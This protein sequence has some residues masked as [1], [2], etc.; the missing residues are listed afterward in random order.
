MHGLSKLT[1]LTSLLLEKEKRD[2]E[3]KERL[4]GKRDGRMDEETKTSVKRLMGQIHSKES[5]DKRPQ[6]AHV[7]QALTMKFSTYLPACALYDRKNTAQ[8][9]IHQSHPFSPHCKALW[10]IMTLVF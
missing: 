10:E 3:I 1:M 7:G 5:R 9:N 8:I 4:R 2:G 6:L